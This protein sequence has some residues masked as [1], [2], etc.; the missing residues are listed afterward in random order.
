MDAITMDSIARG[1]AAGFAGNLDYGLH[2]REMSLREKHEAMA[3]KISELEAKR[4]AGEID[5]QGAVKQAHELQNQLFGGELSEQDRQRKEAAATNEATWQNTLDAAN[6]FPVLKERLNG[7]HKSGASPEIGAQAL[8]QHA[9]QH[10]QDLYSA[11]DAALNDPS[12]S[13]GDVEAIAN[14]TE[15]TIEPG[16]LKLVTLD[17]NGTQGFS[18]KG[19]RTGKP[20]RI[21]RDDLE[22]QH[23]AMHA[24]M[25]GPKIGAALIGDE[26]RQRIAEINAAAR[27]SEAGTRGKTA[28]D[29]EGMRGKTAENVQENRGKTA[30]DVQ[31]LRGGTA[32]TVARTRSDAAADATSGRL[33][34]AKADWIKD[35]AHKLMARNF[36]LTPEQAYRQAVKDYAFV[37]G[38]RL[39]GTAPAQPVGDALDALIRPQATPPAAAVPE[40]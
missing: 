20:F 17:R 35:D 12:I 38:E 6:E 21:S 16:T 8:Q 15:P 25:F 2:E 4:L 39:S 13:L 10:A 22:Q 27:Q 23:R 32:E 29:V 18:F 34:K 28:I 11:L 14:R 19:A 1:M 24:S 30:I 40:Q 31:D 9:Q 5:M 3:Q 37:T 36:A 33:D 7:M 26:T